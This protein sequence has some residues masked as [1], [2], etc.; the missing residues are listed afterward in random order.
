MI[1]PYVTYGFCKYYYDKDSKKYGKIELESNSTPF[2]KEHK[3]FEENILEFFKD[4]NLKVLSKDELSIVI[5]GVKLELKQNNVTV[6]NCLF[7][8]EDE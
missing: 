7:E 8:D 4:Y 5:P 2:L 3:K 1:A 6:Y